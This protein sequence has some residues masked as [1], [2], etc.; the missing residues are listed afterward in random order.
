MEVRLVA[1]LPGNPEA[2]WAT[3]TEELALAL[4]RDGLRLERGPGGGLTQ[5]GEAVARVV[6]WRPGQRAVLE[7]PAPAW[8]PGEPAR[9]ELSVEPAGGGVRVTLERSGA[10]DAVPDALAWAAGALAAPLLRAWAPSGLSAWVT[11]RSA[12]RPS[13][14][15]ARE[16]YRD[17]TYHRPNFGA[18]LEALR[19]TDADELLEVGCGGGALLADALRTGCRAAGVDHSPDMVR[20]A[21]E[22]N[23]EAVAGGRLEVVQADAAALP[24]ADERFTCAAMTGVIGFL[25]DPRAALAEIRRCLRPGGRLALFAGTRKLAG[26]PAAPEPVLHHLRF[27]DAGELERLALDAGFTSARA[28]HPDL[29]PHARRAGLPDDVAAMFGDREG[30]LLLVAVR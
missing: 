27:Y 13:G 16:V 30:S 2:A 14:A 12:R 20:L 22:V 6:E 5:A 24:F 11:D 8:A 17:P 1:E 7:W 10:A 19:L 18:V 28:E 26:T 25:P 3:V 4:E 29:E 21:R 9:V 15:A 23:A